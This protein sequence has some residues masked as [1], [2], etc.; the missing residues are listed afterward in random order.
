E[1]TSRRVQKKHFCAPDLI[2]TEKVATRHRLFRETIGLA[3]VLA[4]EFSSCLC[5][6]LTSLNSTFFG[7][8][9]KTKHALFVQSGYCIGAMSQ[10]ENSG[11]LH[12]NF[13]RTLLTLFGVLFNDLYSLL[14]VHSISELLERFF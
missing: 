5:D 1:E 2:D 14:L 7:L 13:G 4:L 12:S 8:L 11:P 9:V 6:W 3:G 10:V